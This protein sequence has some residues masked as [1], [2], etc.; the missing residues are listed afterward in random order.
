MVGDPLTFVGDPIPFLEDLSPFVGI[1]RARS[2]SAALA[3]PD[4]ESRRPW[5]IARGKPRAMVRRVR[6]PYGSKSVHA[7]TDPR[8]IRSRLGS[9][10]SKV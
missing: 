8:P 9:M 7:K 4:G 1:G 2:D 10:K 3:P 6:R 5:V